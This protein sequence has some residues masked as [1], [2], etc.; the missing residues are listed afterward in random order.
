[1]SRTSSPSGIKSLVVYVLS[2]LLILYTSFAFYPRWNKYGP[3]ATIG[4][5]VSGYYWYLPAAFIYKDVKQQQFKD[6][7]LSKYKPTPDPQQYFLHPGGNYVMKYSAGMAVM[8]SPFFFAAHALARPLGYPPD[9]F[10]APYQF[11]IQAG[12]V[13]IALLGLWWYRRFLKYY[14]DD[15][16]VALVLL[17]LTA[18]SNY[19]NWS[20][21]DGALSHNWLFTLYALLLL[22]TRRFYEAPSVRR[23]VPVGLLVGLATLTRPTDIISCLIPLLWGLERLNISSIRERLR[24]LLR[25]YRSVIAAGVAAALAGSLQLFY[26]KYATGDWIV[27]SYQD[28]GFSWKHPHFYDYTFNFNSGWLIYA[29]VMLLCLPGMLVLLKNGPHRWMVLVF[30]LLNYYIVCAWDI[31]WYGSRAM[32]QSY[33]VLLIAMAALFQWMKGRRWAQVITAPVLLLCLYYNIWF[34][35]NAH[36]GGGAYYDPEGMNR[37]YFLRVA[38]RWHSDEQ[39]YKLK[40]TDELPV[41]KPRDLQLLYRSDSLHL[42][43]AGEEKTR[44]FLR[45]PLAP[46]KGWIRL[47]VGAR[48]TLKEWNTYLMPELHGL[49]YRNGQPVKERMIRLHRFLSD[50]EL[51]TLWIDIRTP[52]EPYDEFRAG[53]R[54]PGDKEIF[55][56]GV[57]IFFFVP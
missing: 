38:G 26:W 23:A 4:W 22:A 36:G 27:Y 2:S 56:E 33:P 50:G 31:W 43:S 53:L 42:S 29:P 32:V 57:A 10:S 14:F 9:G 37:K 16:V 17:M 47:Q 1:M 24:W 20:A 12:S 19:L 8:Y 5:D 21:V 46:K 6:S 55:L 49:F 13:L 28:Q 7:I 40:D 11:A 54:N 34:T 39:L 15:S 30:G 18:G 35:A 52:E 41:D 44:E 48:C 45:L 3:E 51:K 25:Q